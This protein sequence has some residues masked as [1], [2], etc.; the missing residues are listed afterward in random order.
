MNGTAIFAETPRAGE[1]GHRFLVPVDLSVS[2][3]EIAKFFQVIDGDLSVGAN[4]VAIGRKVPQRSAAGAIR[5]GREVVILVGV[6]VSRIS[7]Y[8]LALVLTSLQGCLDKLYHLVNGGI[9]WTKATG[10]GIVRR[11]EL[12]VWLEDLPTDL[13]PVTE[14]RNGPRQRRAL[15]AIPAQPP[16][17]PIYKAT[18]RTCVFVAIAFALGLAG[19]IP[20]NQLFSFGNGVA[21]PGNTKTSEVVNSHSVEPKGGSSVARDPIPDAPTN[22]VVSV[23]VGIADLLQNTIRVGN[24]DALVNMLAMLPSNG[25]IATQDFETLIEFTSRLTKQER[26]DDGKRIVT[27]ISR[28]RGA[29]SLDHSLV[30][31]IEDLQR[32]A[33]EGCESIDQQDRRL[34]DTVRGSTGEEQVKAARRYLEV[35]PRKSMS[36]PVKSLIEWAG[37]TIEAEVIS[38]D[39]PTE[40]P[41]IIKFVANGREIGCRVDSVDSLASLR[42]LAFV[43][44]HI[45]ITRQRLPASVQVVVE[46]N[47]AVPSRESKRFAGRLQIIAQS[48]GVTR[49]KLESPD[50]WRPAGITVRLPLIEAPPELLDWKKESL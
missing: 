3:S 1:L 49:V 5:E 40:A 34:Y 37:K 50:F 21:K 32:K 25:S 8:E 43:M 47:S 7:G 41:W 29:Q 31:R 22:R 36:Q 17:R 45:G 2:E 39:M 15:K 48:N 44:T 33:S 35:G 30:A 13:I 18:W 42:P 11:K 20:V 12:K 9:D 14:W 26:F 6:D 28:L 10:E 19:G 38:V 4:F 24:V 16:Q 23:S 27:Q 46:A